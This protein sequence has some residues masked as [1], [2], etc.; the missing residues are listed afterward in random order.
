MQKANEFLTNQLISKFADALGDLD[1][2]ESS[3]VLS[4]ELKKD[5]LL[6]ND[7]RNVVKKI[8]PYIPFLGFL[9]GG[10]TTVKHVY[11]HKS[12]PK[13]EQSDEHNTHSPD[14]S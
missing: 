1:A 4:E 2:I 6:K 12:K 10:I 8:T 9:S 14:N 11:E 13:S 3:D 7:V 5:D